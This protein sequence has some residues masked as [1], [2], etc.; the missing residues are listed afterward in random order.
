M[1]HQAGEGGR[2]RGGRG[3]VAGS[4]WRKKKTV[5][6][7]ASVPGAQEKMGDV[8]A[9]LLPAVASGCSNGG[10]EGGLEGGEAFALWN[11]RFV[12][13]LARASWPT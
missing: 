3:G 7:A 6:R 9:H 8:A 10:R 13:F 11:V 1:H 2:G 4:G 5:V 12:C